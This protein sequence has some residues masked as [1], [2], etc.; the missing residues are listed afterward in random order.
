MDD[1]GEFVWPTDIEVDPPSDGVV[2]LNAPAGAV[3]VTVVDDGEE[4]SRIVEVE[5]VDA[6]RDS[7]ELLVL[8]S[9]PLI[10]DVEL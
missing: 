5:L 10:V 7:V 8:L 2:E 6:V 4:D 9:L 3:V 1:G